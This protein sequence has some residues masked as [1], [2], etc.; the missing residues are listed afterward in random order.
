MQIQIVQVT[1]FVQNCMILSEAPGGPCVV[2]DP[3]GELDRILAAVR[4]RDLRV[5]GIL[6]THGHIDHIGS[7]DELA[8]ATGAPAWYH[9]DDLFLYDRPMGRRG[10]IRLPANATAVDEGAV[11]SVAGFEFGVLHTPGHSPGSI[12]FTVPGATF[13]GDVLF[14]GSVGRTDLPGASFEVLEASIRDKLWPLDDDTRVFPGHGPPTR[15]GFE[16]EE[17]PFVGKY[18]SF[19]P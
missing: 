18:A 15:I 12:T 10:P 16:K 19:P 3:G 2:I 4:E 9:R 14:Q 1:M 6:V 5:E 7:L 13:V 17:N 8:E 11:I